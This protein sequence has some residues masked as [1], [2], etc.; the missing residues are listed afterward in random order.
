MPVPLEG[1]SGQIVYGTGGP[2][3]WEFIHYG[4][5]DDSYDG[6]RH[7]FTIN[8]VRMEI[9][10]ISARRLLSWQCPPHP[11]IDSNKHSYQWSDA[12]EFTGIGDPGYVMGI[13]ST[14]SRKGVYHVWPIKSAGHKE[15]DNTREDLHEFFRA[16]PNSSALLALTRA[17]EHMVRGSA[18]G[19]Y[20]VDCD[21]CWQLFRRLRQLW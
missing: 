13:Y 17:M 12:W 7:G 1:T 16:G 15:C 14:R 18:L 11:D 3:K 10:I 20:H 19:G 9:R 6:V 4:V 5:L 2:D 21:D 8:G